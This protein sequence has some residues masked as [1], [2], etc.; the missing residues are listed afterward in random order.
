VIV[1][2]LYSRAH[3][4]AF[5]LPIR[6]ADTCCVARSCVPVPY[7]TLSY[8]GWI[9]W[10]VG[11]VHKFW[12]LHIPC[13]GLLLPY[14]M[15]RLLHPTR[16][17]PHYRSLCALPTTLRLRYR[18]GC[19]TATSCLWYLLAAYGIELYNYYAHHPT[20]TPTP[21]TPRLCL[22]RPTHPLFT[23]HPTTHGA[24][25]AHPTRTYPRPTPTL[26]PRPTTTYLPRV[27]APGLRTHTCAF[28]LPR[29][30]DT[31]RARRAARRGQPPIC[32]SLSL[33]LPYALP[34]GRCAALSVSA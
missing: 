31:R 20:H 18:T 25:P 12:H 1:D 26:P 9:D 23:P 8:Y 28:T 21:T 32:Q 27:A 11:S 14:W 13:N 24:A 30:F 22:P 15:A 7:L 34:V 17:P 5:T 3:I 4:K 33:L 29:L 16:S 19:Y 2:S 10:F 6:L